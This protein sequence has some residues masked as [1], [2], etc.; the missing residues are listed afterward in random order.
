[1]CISKSCYY[2]R[3]ISKNWCL[4]PHGWSF[5]LLAIMWNLNRILI[6]RVF[7]LKVHSYCTCAILKVLLAIG[8]LAFHS[9]SKMNKS[10]FTIKHLLTF[11]FQLFTIFAYNICS[12]YFYAYSMIY[13]RFFFFAFFIFFLLYYFITRQI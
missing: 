10:H 3:K 4:W 5:K 9:E 2:S 1:M 8:I 13:L 11:T 6:E 12:E 7:T